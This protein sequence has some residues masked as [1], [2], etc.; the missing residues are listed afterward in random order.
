MLTLWPHQQ[1]AVDKAMANIERGYNGFALFFDPGVGKTGAAITILRNIFNSDKR[2]YRTIIFCPVIVIKN[3]TNEWALFSK[4]DPRSVIPL[5]G[6]GKDRIKKFQ[7]G[8]STIDLAGEKRT[9]S[10]IFITNYEALNNEEL[11]KLFMDWGPEVLVFDESHRL[12]SGKAD[13]TKFSMALSKKAKYVGILTGTPIL[14]NAMDLFTQFMIL[15]K[16]RTFGKNFFVFRGMYFQDKNA[17][18]PRERYFPNWQVKPGALS[19]ISEKIKTVASLAKKEEC[20]DLPPFVRK[21]IK[22]GMSPEQKRMYHEME[23]DFVTFIND[24]A[25]VAT[26]AI[27]K[28]IRLMQILSGFTKTDVGDIVELVN[29]PREQALYEILQDLVPN[30]KVIV[31]AVYQENYKTIARVCDK[32]KVKYVELNGNVSNNNRY[33]NVDTFN[34]DPECRVVIAHPASAGEGINLV[35]SDYYVRYS[36]NF[37]YGES[38]QSE[39]RNYRGGSNIHEKVTGIDL[40]CEKTIDEEITKRLLDKQDISFKVL[41]SIAN[42][43]KGTIK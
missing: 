35:V 7:E 31:W 5:Y 32:L 2:L 36:K 34:N 21:T 24:S 11:F 28:A 30:H 39:A 1:Q 38:V 13:R 43:L 12:K 15:D 33:K 27:T 40:V 42:E 20:L 25:V 16:G 22:V 19:A 17:W 4:I 23:Q 18:M 14:N 3:W 6:S 26:L 8:I 29:T 10:A 41:A 9:T 37:S